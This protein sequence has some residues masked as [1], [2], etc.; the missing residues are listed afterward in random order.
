MMGC[1]SIASIIKII[2]AI[3]VIVSIQ[4]T[5]GCAR[6]S[7][8]GE[9]FLFGTSPTSL[10]PVQ[11]VDA[12]SAQYLV[13]IFSGLVTLDNNLNVIGDIADSWEVSA[14]GTTYTFHIRYGVRFHSGKEVTASDF[15]YSIERAADPQT[16]SPVAEAYLGDIVG[17]KDKLHGMADD[18]RGVLVVDSETLEITIDAPKAYFLAK[19]THPTAFVVDSENVESGEDWWRHPNGT[20]PFLLAE[21]EE[22]QRIALGRNEYYYRGV[23]KLESVTFLLRGNSMMMYENDD[24]SITAV[25][26]YNI[27]RVLDPTNPLNQELMAAPELSVFYVG[28]NTEMPPFDNAGV[29]QAFCHAVDKEKL[30]DV[31]GLGVVLPAYGILPPGMPGY[32]DE[33]EGLGYNVTLAQQLIAESAYHDELPPIVLS[34]MGDCS[35]VSAVDST[36]AWMWQE[37][38]GVNVSIQCVEA[39]TFLDD[40][41]EHE[42]QM[43]KIGWIADYPDPENFLDI[44]FY[45]ESVENH[46]AYSNPEVDELLEEA[47]VESD[48]VDRLAMY[49]DIEQIIVDDA[50]WL[51]L[52]Y[53]KN[54]YLVKPNVMGYS[55]PPMVIPQF[56]DIWIER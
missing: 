40:L 2:I 35:G 16:N 32:D 5:F 48:T 43:F 21:W 12:S 54:Y 17:V 25:S 42:L 49:Q 9:L 13:E 55:P 26:A 46:T 31:L 15:K 4:F 20:G 38:L 14:D 10:D 18:V 39:E 37:N 28:F 19:L 1:S 41:R 23:A 45:S 47:R 50:P 34:D 11:C 6:Y 27:A 53:G 7:S 30:I 33:I 44:L 8:N 52:Y 36:L 3:V 24:I 56:K 51:P 29:R 22:G